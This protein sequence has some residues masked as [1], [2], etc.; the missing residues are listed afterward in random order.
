MGSALPY[1]ACTGACTSATSKGQ[2]RNEIAAAAR[3]AVG[4]SEGYLRDAAISFRAWPFD[5][6]D[7]RVPVHAWYGSADPNYSPRNGTWL[8][9]HAGADLAIRDGAT[10]LATLIDHWEDMLVTLTRRSAGS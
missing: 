3:E 9:E 1:H 7:V 10:H 6:A 8:A 5:V 4:R 2:A